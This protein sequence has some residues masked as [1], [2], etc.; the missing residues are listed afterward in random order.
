MI[1]P[2]IFPNCLDMWKKRN[3]SKGNDR[4]KSFMVPF[5]ELKK[6]KYDF[7]ISRYKEIGYE[8]EEYEEPSD[9][10]EKVVNIN[11]DIDK[12]INSLKRLIQNENNLK[13]GDIADFINGHAFKP[14]DWNGKGKKIIRIQNLTDNKK[15]YNMT[16]KEV[17]KKYVVKNGDLLV[18]WS[19]T[20]DVFSW[21]G[22][23]ALLNQHIFKVV[24]KYD[25]VNKKIPEI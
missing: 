7:S 14:T 10:I 24:P 3:E 16:D 8:E 12:Q 11:N 22:E 17:D 19:A 15:P 20:L 9:L 5:E 13:L 23:D 25:L 18:S 6:N 21:E 2:E 1:L 4:I